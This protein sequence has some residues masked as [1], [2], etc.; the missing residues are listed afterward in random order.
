L[1]ECGRSCR[2]RLRRAARP[3]EWEHHRLRHE[4]S[5]GGKWLELLSE[6]APGLKRAAL[7]FNPDTAGGSALM[8]RALSVARPPGI[9]P[10]FETA[11]R[12]LKVEPIILNPEVHEAQFSYSL[13]RTRIF[14]KFINC[15]AVQ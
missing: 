14:A 2:Q 5:L 13:E 4:G 6:I 12:S 7:M 3:P 15:G 8:D 11:A 10:S 1:C 9:R